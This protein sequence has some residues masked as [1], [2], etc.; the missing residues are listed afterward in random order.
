MKLMS[1]SSICGIVFLCYILHSTYTLYMLFRAPQCTDTPCYQSQLTKG[2]FL[3]LS[4]YTSAF[5]NP[6]SAAK[7]AKLGTINPFDPFIELEKSYTINL[8]KETRS[9]GTLYMFAVLTKGA[10]SLDWDSVRSQST[11]VIKK[12]GLTHYMVPKAATI[13]LLN[14]KGS[15]KRPARAVN[16]KRVAHIRQ[17][18]FIHIITE[19]FSVSPRDVPAELARDIRITPDNLVMPI[20][21]NDF[22][23][24]KLA[25]L[26]EIDPKATEATVTIHYAPSSVGKIKMLAQIERAMSDLTRLGFSEKDIDEVKSIFSDTNVYLLCGTIIISSVHLLID[27]LSFKNDILFWKHKRTYAGLSL[28]STLW[29]TFS[30]I[31]IFLYLMDEETSLLILIP[32]GIGTLI[33]VWKAKKILKLDVSLRHG[34]RFRSNEEE[35][36][37]SSDIQ[38][39]ENNTLELDKEAMRYLSFVLYPLCIAGAIYSLLYLP[40]KSWYSWT[41]SSMANGVYAF[42]FLF[43]LPQLFINYK[44]KSVAAL[45]WRVFMY[46]SFNTFIDDVFAFIITMPTAHRFACFRDDIVF[47]VYLYQRWLYPVDKTR[48]DEDERALMGKEPN[49]TDTKEE[50]QRLKKLDAKENKKDN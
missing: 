3:Q 18:V 12:F 15:T 26:V 21:R 11:S 42:G 31:I 28:R 20:I 4:L 47:L 6:T 49:S 37:V 2:K 7:V 19:H 14:D 13:N 33:E 38:T 22:A 5:A 23:K 48:I 1:L 10:K 44:L 40:H 35:T 16:Q 41:I 27:F 25:D 29:R 17:N 45:P 34:I 43:M 39:Q 46:K 30:H 8:P 50:E 9:N 36:D 24:E 32:T